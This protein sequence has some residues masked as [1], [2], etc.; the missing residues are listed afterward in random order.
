VSNDQNWLV[1]LPTTIAACVDRWGLTLGERLTGGLVGHVFACT[2][3]DGKSAVLK[4]N[5]PSA[6][7]FAGPPNHEA[8]ALSAW[9]GRGAVEL[10]AFAA[11]LR[12][13]L[14]LRAIPGTPLQPGNE[15]EALREVGVLLTKL[16]E[17]TAP[18]AGIRPLADVV[19][20]YLEMKIAAAGE[21]QRLLGPLVEL[22]GISAQRLASSLTNDVLLHGDL[23]D[24]N[25]L[26]DHT[27]LVAIDPAPAIGDPSADI[28]FW[29]ATR[30]P[31]DGIE[32]RAAE[33]ARLVG[34][35][36]ERAERWSAVYAVGQACES[37]RS[38][39]TELRAWAQSA[40]AN[41]LLH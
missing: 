31:V 3:G 4:L 5:P 8:A 23:M 38:D 39:T 26:R 29:A 20:Q 19:R 15:P 36:P 6:D 40:R 27:D 32:S 12:A 18:A 9:R 21:A 41:E 34:T 35:D 33:L 11:D 30:S 24:K 14:T 37:W 7:A 10:I 2:T 25:L 28:G 22:A 13:L 17:A 16:F 1:E